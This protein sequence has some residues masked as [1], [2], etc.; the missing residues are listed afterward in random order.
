M[1]FCSWSILI[2][3]LALIISKNSRQNITFFFKK[4]TFFTLIIY[5]MTLFSKWLD[6]FFIS[7]SHTLSNVYIFR[8]LKRNSRK[9]TRSIYQHSADVNSMKCEWRINTSTS[10]GL[11]WDSACY[12]MRKC[13][14]QKKQSWM[15]WTTRDVIR[16]IIIHTALTSH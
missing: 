4:Y 10:Y 12:K 7:G 13:H 15:T 3:F 9:L 5:S 6:F 1:S 2:S 14:N 8:P 11:I 16:S